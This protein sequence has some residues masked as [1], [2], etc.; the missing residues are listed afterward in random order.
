M[1]GLASVEEGGREEGRTDVGSCGEGI[2]EVVGARKRGVGRGIGG[3]SGGICCGSLYGGG[4]CCRHGGR[5]A[6]VE[7]VWSEGSR[8]PRSV[9]MRWYE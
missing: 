5:F 6:G 2:A 1:G 7:L 3:R 8:R 4:I 9:V